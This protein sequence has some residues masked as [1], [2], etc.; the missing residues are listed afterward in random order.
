[1][2]S[3]ASARSAVSRALLLAGAAI[4][5]PVFAA[6]TADTPEWI[7][8]SNANAQVL[9]N[10]LAK[11]GPEFAGRIG[12]QGFD[13]KITDLNPGF[14]E[15]V[16]AELVASHAELEKRI[17][18]ETD[19]MV[20]QDLQI[21]VESAANQLQTNALNKRLV[22]PYADITQL[23]FFGEFSLLDDQVDAARR[24]AALA[25]LKRYVGLEPGTKSVVELVKARYIAQAAANPALLPPYKGEVEKH[26][27]AI[28]RYSAGIRQL[29]TKYG[30]DKL[31]GAPAALDA[32]DAQFKAYTE[33][34]TTTVLPKARTDYRLPAELY[35]DNL[36]NVGLDIP[37]QEL[38]AR[39]QLA[40]TE[41]R[42]E[43]KAIAPLGA[44]S[45]A[46][47][48]TTTAPSSRR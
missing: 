11:N 16:R 10:S 1:M 28:P 29:Y 45:T 39:A 35:A 17:L 9:V 3:S 36:K 18:S 20:R 8:K 21:L 48:T 30:I 25:R 15:R 42:N 46:L 22:L 31:E 40:F 38:M 13:D 6:S 44:S 41:I 4:S 34:L 47:P 26:L 32:L 12:V 23:V 27:T 14:E 33:W 24:P 5:L 7:A 43:M 2:Q 19:P 37:P